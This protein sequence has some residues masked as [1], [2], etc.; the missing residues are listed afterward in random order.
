MENTDPNFHKLFSIVY[1]CCTNPLFLDS[2]KLIYN[3]CSKNNSIAAIIRKKKLV[4]QKIAKYNSSF[5]YVSKGQPP[6][7]LQQIYQS[8]IIAQCNKKD[9]NMQPNNEK[10]NNTYKETLSAELK[11][12][13]VQQPALLIFVTCYCFFR[14]MT[15]RMCSEN[16]WTEV[17]GVYICFGITR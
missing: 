10:D 5:I 2:N 14:H 6:V 12:R 16:R 15:W 13:K 7:E 11:F 9:N 1:T 17:H 8:K 3:K 4:D